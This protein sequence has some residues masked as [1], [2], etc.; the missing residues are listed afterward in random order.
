MTLTIFP[1]YLVIPLPKK[2][3]FLISYEKLRKDD[4]ES[5]YAKQVK[6]SLTNEHSFLAELII[7]N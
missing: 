2:Y 7:V 3:M 6:I 5:L 1:N 4:N